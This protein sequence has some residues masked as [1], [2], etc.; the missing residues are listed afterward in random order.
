M[1]DR[2]LLYVNKQSIISRWKADHTLPVGLL[3]NRRSNS[4]SLLGIK[5]GADQGQSRE[6]SLG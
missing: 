4:R 3:R 2:A 5:I 6:V 1:T